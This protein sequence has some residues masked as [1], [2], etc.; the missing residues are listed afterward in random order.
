MQ[1][2]FA[3]WEG[4]VRISGTSGGVAVTGHGFVELTGY[5]ASMQGVF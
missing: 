5:A 1:L 2:M 4:A 3:Y